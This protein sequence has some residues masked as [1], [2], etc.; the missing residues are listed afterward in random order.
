MAS[1]SS[2]HGTAPKILESI[3]QAGKKAFDPSIDELSRATGAQEYNQLIERY[4]S[5]W[6]GFA[7]FN[8]T[9]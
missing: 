1:S 7:D 3:V 5:R 9:N 4:A 2:T 8:Y 6:R